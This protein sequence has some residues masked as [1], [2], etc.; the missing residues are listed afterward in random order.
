VR[1]NACFRARSSLIFA[2]HRLDPTAL[3][4]TSPRPSTIARQRWDSLDVAR[5]VAILAMIAYHFSWDL[6]F[7]R[8]IATNIVAE[9]AWQWF[10]RC[11]AGSFLFLA[12]TGLVLAHEQGFRRDRFLLRL[13]KVGGAALAITLVTVLAF[14]DSY[15]FFGILHCIAAASVLALPFLRAPLAVTL[16]A[17]ACVL[18]APWFLTDPAFDRP[19]LDWLGFGAVPPRTNDYVPI[20]PWFGLVLLG[21]AAGRVL[22]RRGEA[23]PLA[24]WRASGPF[25]RLLKFAGRK[26]L[27][28]YLIHQPILLA[29]LWGVLQVTGPS[30]LAEAQPFLRECRAT[31]L[32][33]NGNASLCRALCDCA[34]DRL[35]EQGLWAEV[36]AGRV[37]P[38][39]RTRISQI[40]QQCLAGASPPPP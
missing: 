19:A 10:A 22:V 26:S 33:G 8:L 4:R 13:A 24:R 21:V 14:P 6:S 11:I 12:G 30:P 7:L 39:N 5:G 25:A 38:A 15:I 35:R 3:N 31:C 20:F 28:I 23:L 32:E 17:A 37:S 1:Q 18:A 29:L 9:P 34:V 27:P 40:A 36:A 16:A 2:A